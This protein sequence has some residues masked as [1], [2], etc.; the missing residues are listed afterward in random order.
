MEDADVEEKLASCQTKSEAF[1]NAVRDRHI[2]LSLPFSGTPLP[3][4]SMVKSGPGVTLLPSPTEI[5]DLGALISL[6]LSSWTQYQKL[7]TVEQVR[8]SAESMEV[9]QVVFITMLYCMGQLGA[10]L[11]V[12]C[13]G[14]L[15]TAFSAFD[16]TT[17]PEGPPITS[18]NTSLKRT[19][20][21]LNG[22]STTADPIK[23]SASGTPHSA[24][25]KRAGNTT[26]KK[27][28][29]RSRKAAASSKRV[30]AASAKGKTK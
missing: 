6:V 24:V 5:R 19:H 28:R 11:P 12:I 17:D 3:D 18:Q 10:F 23:N 4:G 30:S 29:R 7:P 27:G 9:D 22:P 26:K 2:T 13:S 20:R 25:E 8:S 21:P 15:D 1:Y 14:D 16:L